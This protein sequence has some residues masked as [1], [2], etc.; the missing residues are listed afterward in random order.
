[1]DF[2]ILE[3]PYLIGEIGINHNGDIQ[4]AKKLIDAVHAC[5]W[6][7]AKF[8]KRTPE[9]CVPEEQKN[10]MRD[11]P[12]GR[13]TYLDY[14]KRIEFNE[15]EYDY[16]NNYCQEKPLDW[17]ASVWDIP[18]LEFIMKYSI[19]FIKIPS[20][21]VTNHE[22]LL[23][24]AKTGKQVLLS[25]GMSTLKEVDIAVNLFLKNG[26]NP[27]LLHTN[28][29]YPA[30]TNELNL[31]LIPFYKERYGCT[32]GYSGHEEDLT[33]TVVAVVLG[34]KI[35]ERH[36]TLSHSLWGTDQKAS[37]ELLAMDMLAKRIK[38][39]KLMIGEPKKIVYPSEFEARK[40]LR[41]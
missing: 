32:I 7:C 18:S 28:S 22:L 23:Q 41:K 25:T 12:W 9:L 11:T 2:E 20:A 39:I 24:V 38:N 3:T 14:K 40:R 30:P 6:N 13:I 27:I 33:P 37:L 29:S 19:P 35:V 8:Q 36:I 16:L 15:S 34:A 1:M 4:I 21:M 10:I 17:T 26:C 31:S 5:G